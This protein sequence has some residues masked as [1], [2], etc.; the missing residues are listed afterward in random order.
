MESNRGRQSFTLV[1]VF[2]AM[3]FG[4]VLAGG[5][6]LTP[7]SNAEPNPAMSQPVSVTAPIGALP[8][9]ADLAEAVSPAVVSIQATTIERGS[10]AVMW[11]RPVTA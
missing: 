4:M 8:G 7:S 3:V 11:R 9:F 2:G 5:T 10:W 6:N 1:L